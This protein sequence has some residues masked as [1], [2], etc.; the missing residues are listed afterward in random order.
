MWWSEKHVWMRCLGKGSICP[1]I[2]ETRQLMIRQG[3]SFEAIL[4]D[5]ISSGM[6]SVELRNLGFYL[7]YLCGCDCS[8]R[9]VLN[10]EKSRPR[11]KRG[12]RRW[13]FAGPLI[14]VRKRQRVSSASSALN[15]FCTSITYPSF[16]NVAFCASGQA[17]PSVGCYTHWKFWTTT[18][19]RSL[20]SVILWTR[21]T[22]E[23][24]GQARVKTDTR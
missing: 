20:T 8:H 12:G 3:S 19:L 17:S 23:S 9:S 10:W 18:A 2:T 24:S 1:K 22:T 15:N 21:S 7:L 14:N 13:S 6:L 5:V 11:S 4:D 16:T